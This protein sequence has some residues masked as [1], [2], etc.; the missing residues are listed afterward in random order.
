MWGEVGSAVGLS[1]VGMAVLSGVATEAGA[2]P[3]GVEAL[4]VGAEVLSGTGVR[5]G[6]TLALPA[7]ET[8]A[9]I[10]G[11]VGMLMAP[12]TTTVDGA[13]PVYQGARPRLCK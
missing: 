10:V 3:E 8:P 5:A 11:V 7:G 12:P 1:G 6:T 2:V 9:G 13:A 4:L